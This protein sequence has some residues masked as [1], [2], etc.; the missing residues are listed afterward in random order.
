[1]SGEY[2]RVEA[3]DAGIK[4]CPENDLSNGVSRLGG[5]A[6]A[7]YVRMQV[8]TTFDF[9]D[10]IRILLRGRVTHTVVVR[11]EYVVGRIKAEPASIYIHPVFTP[12]NRSYESKAEA[13]KPN[14]DNP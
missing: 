4:R 2:G 8:E 9:F 12:R 6:Y 3:K 10:R 1:V 14:N 5:L 11:T 13:D 7:D